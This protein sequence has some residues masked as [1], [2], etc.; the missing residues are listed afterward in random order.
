MPAQPVHSKLITAAAREVLRPLGLA[1][2]GRSRVGLD[3]HG[4]WL[5]TVSFQPSSY[6]RGAYLNVG[7]QPIWTGAVEPSLGMT[8]LV[9]RVRWRSV[10]GRSI[11]F[12]EFENEHQFASETRCLAQ[13]AASAVIRLRARFRTVAAWAT[14][15]FVER[16]ALA[17]RIELEFPGYRPPDNFDVRYH[18]GVVSGLAGNAEESRSFLAEAADDREESLRL[19]AATET[20]AKHLAFGTRGLEAWL[21]ATRRLRDAADDSVEFHG[22]VLDLVRE[23]R[24]WNRLSTDRPIWLGVRAPP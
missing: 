5:V 19:L 2:K 15:L 12:A 6:M 3:D 7:A 17:R 21:H 13:A 18:K 14:Y 9:E 4:W 20:R 8:G 22:V 11:T 24:A 1:Q 23:Y 16:E 10:G